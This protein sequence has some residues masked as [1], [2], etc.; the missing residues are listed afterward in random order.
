MSDKDPDKN[1]V[2]RNGTYY[3]RAKIKSKIIHRSLRTDDVTVAREERDKILKEAA[4][5]AWRGNRVVMWEDAVSEWFDHEGRDL[6]YNTGKR[7]TMSLRQAKPFFAEFNISAINGKTIG[8]FAKMRKKQGASNATI[9]RDLTAISRVLDYSI[10]ENWREDNPTLSRRR[11][12]KERRDPITLP[13]PEDIEEIIAATSPEFAAVIRAAWLTGCRQNEII[14]ARWRDYDATRGT[15]RIVGKGNKQ[16][17]ISLY[18]VAGKD[19]TGFFASL[20]RK[21]GADLIFTNSLG[22][23]FA[24]ASSDFTHLR[25]T[26]MARAEKEGRRFDRFRFHDLRHLFAVEALRDGMNIYDLQQHMGHSSVKVTEVYLAH[27]THEEK[28][29]AKGGSAAYNQCVTQARNT[30]GLN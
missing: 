22:K 14:T 4:D 16:R 17:V 2:C 27:L 26:V 28:A 21:F 20:P 9:R 1:L 6:P 7:Y 19:A 15:L 23:A 18:P 11:L 24:Q 13:L 25:R 10:M 3:V 12:I 29:R 5:W 8:D 30:S